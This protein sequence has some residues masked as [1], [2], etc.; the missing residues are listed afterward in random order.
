M[1]SQM[2]WERALAWCQL[3]P[4]RKLTP[5]W[6]TLVAGFLAIHLQKGPFRFY[7]KGKGA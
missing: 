1:H 6:Y 3:H 7:Q 4:H 2:K 5:L